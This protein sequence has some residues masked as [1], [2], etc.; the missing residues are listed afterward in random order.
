MRKIVLLTAS[1]VLCLT[2]SL[3]SAKLPQFGLD[4]GPIRPNVGDPV[5]ITMTCY[6]DA[7]HTQARSSC[8]GDRGVMAWV[9]PLETPAISIDPTGSRW[10]D[11]PTSSGASRGRIT[12][13]EPGAYD[14]LPLWRTW[15]ADAGDGFPWVIL[16]E[17][18]GGTRITPVALTAFGVVGTCLAVV[19]WIRR[20]SVTAVTR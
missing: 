17:V 4:V 2:P 5:T 14:V 3:A 10:R 9:H 8:F 1:I 16:I 18:T 20:T 15:G 7:D 13:D 6:V 19:A 12:L 11:A